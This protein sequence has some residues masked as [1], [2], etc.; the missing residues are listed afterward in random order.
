MAAR[1]I[2][3]HSIKTVEIVH[4]QSGKGEKIC[5]RVKNSHAGRLRTSRLR[6]KV[7]VFYIL[8]D[9]KISCSFLKRYHNQLV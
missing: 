5:V 4:Q 8:Q 2:P 9:I 6:E 1:L 3:C 7:M